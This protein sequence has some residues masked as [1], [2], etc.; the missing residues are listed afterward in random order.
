MMHNIVRAQL[1]LKVGL[2]LLLI[3]S[4]CILFKRQTAPSCRYSNPPTSCPK[5]GLPSS[6]RY[7]HIW[8]SMAGTLS[9]FFFLASLFGCQAD[10]ACSQHDCKLS[11][12]LFQGSARQLNLR[13]PAAELTQH[14]V[15]ACILPMQYR[16]KRPASSMAC[17][18]TAL[19]I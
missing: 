4:C 18:V 10:A 5:S 11:M 6:P 13:Q 8:R 17:M 7:I 15:L 19:H 12:H 14:L 16:C 2:P 1:S 3:V 9:P